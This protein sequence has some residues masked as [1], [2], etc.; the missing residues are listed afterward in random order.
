MP[1]AS[2]S[3]SG[4]DAHET[5]NGAGR[6]FDQVPIGV[7]CIGLT[8]E[9]REI[10]RPNGSFPAREYTSGDRFESRGRGNRL[11]WP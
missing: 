5:G 10:V 3:E 2:V 9:N 11:D 8:P 7:W 1:I 4:G 6:D